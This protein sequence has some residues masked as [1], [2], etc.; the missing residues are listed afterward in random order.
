MT[1]DLIQLVFEDSKASI[2]KTGSALV[3]LTLQGDH[4]MPEPKS[5][6]SLYHGVLLAPWPNRIARGKYHFESC[7][8]G[9][10]IPMITR[11]IRLPGK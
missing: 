5:P 11:K 3:S 9:S 6:R 1:N 7:S 2:A 10:R 8:P 4:V